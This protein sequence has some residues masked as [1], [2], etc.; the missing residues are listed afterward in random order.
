MDNPYVLE[1]LVKFKRGICAV[2]SRNTCTRYFETNFAKTSRYQSTAFFSV[3]R[4]VSMA[5]SRG[6]IGLDC[7]E[8]TALGHE[9]TP[10]PLACPKGG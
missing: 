4:G 2:Q 1:V 5:F 8:N 3:T 7:G 10:E 6:V 9:S